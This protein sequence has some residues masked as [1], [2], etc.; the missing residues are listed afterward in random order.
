MN[1]ITF[2]FIISALF[3]TANLF[4]QSAGYVNVFIGTENAGN[5]FPGATLP[6]GMVQLSP[7]AGTKGSFSPSGYFYSADTVYGFS[8]THTSGTALNDM[9]DI[10]FLPTTKKVEIDNR[11]AYGNFMKSHYSQF[12]HDQE[13]AR[14]GFYSVMLNNQEI[15]VSLTCTKRCGFQK[16]EV[17]SGNS[18]SVLIDLDFNKVSD[19]TLLASI[20][21]VNDSLI[22]GYRFS[23]SWMAPSQKVFF[24]TRFSSPILHSIC[25]KANNGQLADF[26]SVTFPGL[27][28]AL[29]FKLAE[30]QLFVK[31]AISS[32]S[33]ES[34]LNN[35]NTE[36][37]GWN[38]DVIEKNAY[39]EWNKL[40]NRVEITSDNEKQKTI[41]YTALYHSAVAPCLLSDVNGKYRGADDKVHEAKGFDYYSCFSLWD[42]YRG[43][44]PLLNLILPEKINAD[45]IKTMLAHFEQVGH[46]PVWTLWGK[47]NW[48]MIGNHAIPVIVDAYNSGIKGFDV[49][50]AYNAIKMTSLDTIW[51]MSFYR[52]YGYD[53][54][55]LDDQS[56]SKTLEYAYNDWCV[57]LMAKSLGKTDDF[58][59]FYNQSQS[60]VNVFDKQ[61]CFMRPRS[62]TGDWVTNFDPLNYG[63]SYTEANAFQYSAYVPHE[64]PRLIE[65]MGGT[66]KMEQWLDTLF[67]K[68]SRNSPFGEG[69]YLG[70]YW[71]SN[72][73][74]HHLAYLYDFVGKPSKTQKMVHEIQT[75]LHTDKPDGI[76]GN[77]DCGQMSAWYVFSALGFYPV[78]P[79]QNMYYIGTPL[80][81]KAVVHLANGKDLIIKKENGAGQNIYIN[82]FSINGKPQNSCNVSMDETKKGGEWIFSMQ[83]TPIDFT[84]STLL[85]V[86]LGKPKVANPSISSIPFISGK[87]NIKLECA[88]PGAKIY[89]TTDGTNPLV[90]SH[91]YNDSVFLDKDTLYFVA[92][93][94]G[95]T[96]SDTMLRVIP[97]LAQSKAVIPS[98]TLKQ[99]LNYS[100]FEQDIS[101]KMPDF[102]LLKP[103]SK[104]IVSGFNMDD[105]KHREENW[106]ISFDG[107]IKI[108]RSDIYLFEL[109]SDDGAI[110][111][112]DGQ[113]LVNND[114]CHA[115]LAKSY[116]ASLEKGF[117]KIRVEF[118]N[119]KYGASLSVSW[120][121]N[122]MKSANILAPY[123]FHD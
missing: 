58:N 28:A 22:V 111:Y 59:F 14:P 55:D 71:H 61:T 123:L 11:N 33:I 9:M 69:G 84:K 83:A 18:L 36:I 94:D 15:K 42:T 66:Q 75:K 53:P 81:D 109:S 120:S 105:I 60:F 46:L 13:V 93:K 79:G 77:D 99:G 86:S 87:G 107:Y 96:S 29:F 21:I 118:Y 73:P 52:K 74:S 115:A 27:K 112:I 49:D 98:G 80:F 119:G 65:L 19:K 122:S 30:K 117:H 25:V 88:T 16:Y 114:G 2:T 17:Q 64:I 37:P 62:S 113:T 90:L 31:T 102:S 1:K 26:D 108:E 121:S 89:Y 12:S 45:F 54:A 24:A 63:S 78:C 97:N 6:F 104:G 92:V 38:F 35:L 70:Q 110:L 57:A 101:C 41:F 91:V 48:C 43:V 106:L 76:P 39:N 4:A 40:L 51:G 85:Q 116:A 47:E 7:D 34:A 103:L 20:K 56:I 72:E 8:H 10:S 95:S 68:G 23:D 50:A 3:Y 82:S 67:T 5:T 44:H 32:V 100:Y